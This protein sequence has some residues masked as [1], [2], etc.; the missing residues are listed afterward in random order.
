MSTISKYEAQEAGRMADM[1]ERRPKEYMSLLE[2]LLLESEDVA[3]A[4]G[5]WGLTDCTD[6]TG[7][8]Y[9]SQTCASVLAIIR[10]ERIARPTQGDE[11]LP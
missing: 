7:E 10:S 11:K 5:Q 4:R 8:H 9:Q 1:R 6:R 3:L 2:T